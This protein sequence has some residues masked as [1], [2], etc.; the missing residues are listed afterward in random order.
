MVL[1]TTFTESGNPRLSSAF[2]VIEALVSTIVGM[3]CMTAIMFIF[4]FANRSFRA[5]FNYVDLNTQNRVAVDYLTREIRSANRV[6]SVS[7][8]SLTLEDFDGVS[9]T[10]TYAPTAGTLTRVKNGV[11]RV[12]LSG[13]DRL[14]FELGERNPVG[15]SYDVYPAASPATAKVI[16]LSWLCTRRI[17]GI[18]QNSESV[19]TARI[20][21]RKQGT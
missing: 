13:C 4:L 6:L 15:G 7:T 8:N 1:K 14:T 19:Q 20:V 21:I 18:K 9:L 2:S 11:S 16:D 10:Y 5:I 12:L 17:L 3:L